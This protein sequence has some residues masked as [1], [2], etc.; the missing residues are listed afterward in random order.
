MLLSG[1]FVDAHAV[2]AVLFMDMSVQQ[3]LAVISSSMGANEG[4]GSRR[5][6]V[7]KGFSQPFLWLAT[8][9][10]H[11]SAAMSQNKLCRLINHRL[12][13]A[14]HKQRPSNKEQLLAVGRGNDPFS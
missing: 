4:A 13:I 12:T 7:L 8:V 6:S 2:V 5:Q 11:S 14:P 10:L 3:F 9:L 1:W